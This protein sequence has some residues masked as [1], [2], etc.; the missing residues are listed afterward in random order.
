MP[1]SFTRRK[2][3]AQPKPNAKNIRGIYSAFNANNFARKTLNEMANIP[4][5]A[6]LKNYVNTRKAT[7]KNLEKN[8]RYSKN[9]KRALNAIEA[10][11]KKRANKLNAP[12]ENLIYFN[13][14]GHKAP[15]NPFN[16]NAVQPIVAPF[17]PFNIFNANTTRKAPSATNKKIVDKAIMR[18]IEVAAGRKGTAL[19]KAQFLFES[20]KHA[21]RPAV[22]AT[23]FAAAAKF[24][25]IE[26]DVKSTRGEIFGNKNTKSVVR[27]LSKVAAEASKLAQ[28]AAAEADTPQSDYAAQ[29][30]RE[31]TTTVEPNEYEGM[32]NPWKVAPSKV[33]NTNLNMLKHIPFPSIY[34][35]NPFL[36]VMETNKNKKNPFKGTRRITGNPF[37]NRAAYESGRPLNTTPTGNPFG[38]SKRSKSWL[39]RLFRK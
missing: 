11:Y 27:M 28:E 26:A 37:T 17:N 2:G 12:I 1:W 34:N 30:A 18:A 3:K 15:Y 9:V 22:K 7:L 32:E 16:N 21:N 19:E 29:V 38:S 36:S 39:K 24:A 35:E 6:N 8:P 33:N 20:G 10:A 13:T 23:Q 5:K 14:T 31:S 4:T 25:Q